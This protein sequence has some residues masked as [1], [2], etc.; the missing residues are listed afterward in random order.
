MNMER[1]F[2]IFTCFNSFGAAA[3]SPALLAGT[4]AEQQASCQSMAKD[5]HD[6]SILPENLHNAAIQP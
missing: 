4:Q 2:F 1:L 6:K 3:Q 5:L